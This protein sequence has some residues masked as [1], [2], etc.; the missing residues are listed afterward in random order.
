MGRASVAVPQYRISCALQVKHRASLPY[1]TRGTVFCRLRDDA[2]VEQKRSMYDSARAKGLIR[3][4]LSL[5]SFVRLSSAELAANEPLRLTIQPDKCCKTHG[6]LRVRVPP[7][8]LFK[9]VAYLSV[10]KQC[11]RRGGA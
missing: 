4:E 8:L 11:I 9:H 2:A 6:R 10:K 3:S 7:S 5:I 1:Q